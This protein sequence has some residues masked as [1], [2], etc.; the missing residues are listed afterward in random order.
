MVLAKRG[1]PLID[2]LMARC[3]P[4]PNSGCWLWE[5]SMAGRYGIAFLNG[6]KVV[7]AHRAML[8]AHGHELGDASVVMHRCDN[9]L[10]V[11]PEHLTVGTQ[12]E[13]LADMSS[14]GRHRPAYKIAKEWRDKIREEDPSFPTWALALWFGVSQKTIRNIRRGL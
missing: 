10:C 5:G 3:I 8:I 2:R 4:E 13:N 1:A 6:T 14:K 7:G 11:N 12:A 9:P